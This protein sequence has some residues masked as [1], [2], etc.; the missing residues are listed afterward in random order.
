MSARLLFASL[1]LAG[2]AAALPRSGAY[3]HA[4]SQVAP[5]A[6]APPPPP[7]SDSEVV[8]FEETFTSTKINTSVWKHEIT[9]AGGGNWEFEYYLNNRSVSYITNGSLVIDPHLTADMIGANGLTSADISLWSG[10]FAT[11]CTNNFDYGCERQGGANIIN[12]VTS[13]AIR[14]AE[15]FNFR[16]GRVEVVARLPKG[17]WMWPAIWM[18]P[19]Q[20]A[21]GDWPA[22]GE[23]DIVESRGNAR[24]YAPGGCESVS[25]TIHYGPFWPLDGYPNTHAQ[26]TAPSGDLSTDFH[27][28]GFFWNSTTMMTYI[29][30][31]TI[32]SVDINE[33]FYARGGFP[34][35]SDNPWRA[36]GLNAPFDER[37][38]LVMNVAVGGTNSYFPDNV[39]G[40]PW[41]DTSNDAANEFWNGKAQWL[42]TWQ[43]GSPMM[44]DSV[45]VWQDA[46]SLDFAL[47]PML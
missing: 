26:Y 8:I 20:S 16:Y 3:S 18:L 7:L 15:S 23:I 22:S 37:F 34:A 36:G 45:R 35:T 29:D 13:A 14:T 19:A 10:D 2:A 4:Y 32:L 42:P 27:T 44:I 12:P 46:D 21:Y 47:R 28:Y 24:G 38:Y 43:A 41:S 5:R 6:D 31:T 9:L 30:T 1:S 25:S 39:G 33:T 17:D 11:T 40:K